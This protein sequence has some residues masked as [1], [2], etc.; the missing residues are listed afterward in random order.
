[1]VEEQGK[2]TCDVCEK[3]IGS[4]VDVLLMRYITKTTDNC[5]LK[6]V[7]WDV[8]KCIKSKQGVRDKW[9]TNLTLMR[10]AL[11]SPLIMHIAH[12]FVGL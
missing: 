4:N 6:I 11:L 8:E 2:W 9:W 10:S 3:G 5:G 7:E 12:M 1:M